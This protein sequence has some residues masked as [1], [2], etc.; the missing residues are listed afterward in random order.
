MIVMKCGKT[1]Y[2][3]RRSSQRVHDQAGKGYRM[4]ITYTKQAQKALSRLDTFTEEKQIGWEAKSAKVV[5]GQD[6]E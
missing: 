4:N 6:W 5:T 3:S 2:G 1:A